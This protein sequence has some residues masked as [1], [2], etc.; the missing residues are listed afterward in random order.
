MFD[1]VPLVLMKDIVNYMPQLKYMFANL[2]APQS[3]SASKR[4]RIS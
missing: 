1:P 3:S 2:A 4:M